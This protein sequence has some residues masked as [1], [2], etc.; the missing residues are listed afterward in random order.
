MSSQS[1]GLLIGGVLP[2]VLFAVSGVFTKQATSLGMGTGL[3][4]TTLGVS[5]TIAGLLVFILQPDT[6]YS[7]Q[8]VFHA[9]FAGFTWAIGAALLAYALTVLHAPMSKLIPIY[10]LNTL[11]GVALILVIFA[12]WKQVHVPKLLIGSVLMTLGAIVVTR[13]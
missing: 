9:F 2:A 1:L 12:E 7:F 13:A 3:Y 10:N 8:S 6:T 4:V 11:I 5:I